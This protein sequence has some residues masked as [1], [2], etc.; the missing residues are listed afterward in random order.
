MSTAP[1][2]TFGNKSFQNTHLYPIYYSRIQPQYNTVAP[3]SNLNQ[4]LLTQ[5]Y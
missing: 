4:T 3:S 1:K 2:V 5:Y